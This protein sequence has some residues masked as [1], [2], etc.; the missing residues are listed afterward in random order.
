MEK[1]I[2]QRYSLL[3]PILP[4]VNGMMY[5]GKDL[6]LNRE[7]ILHLMENDDPAF[8]QAYIR[9]LRDVASFSDNRFLHILD[10][11]VDTQGVFAVL[12]IFGGQPLIQ[13]L[14]QHA[15]ST[16]EILG[17]LFALGKGMQDAMEAGIQGYSVLA[18]NLWVS[19]EGQLKVINYWE[20]GEPRARGAAGLCR[21]LAQLIS[22]SELMDGDGEA[23]ERVV[24]R[25]STDLPAAQQAVLL[26]LIREVRL[27]QG[28][29][30]SF[31]LGLQR[32]LDLPRSAPFDSF[33]AVRTTQAVPEIQ[34]DEEEY[35][36]EDEAAT[37]RV[38][39]VYTDEAKPKN[40]M[41][42]LGIILACLVVVMG[43]LVVWVN[44]KFVRKEVSPA[45][46]AAEKP[47]PTPTTPE[48]QAPAETDKNTK[49][50]VPADTGGDGPIEAPNLVGLTQEEAGKRAIDAGLKYQFFLERNANAQGTV[51]KQDPPA[52][53]QMEKGESVTF[54]V[55][56]GPD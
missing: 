35:E 15:W 29:L 51:F 13:M 6:S 32:L 10:M 27:E 24:R 28:T 50:S 37:R 14:R 18:D 42:R 25:F 38:H 33:E 36:E 12:K 47:A 7:V 23:V 22:R 11:G 41:L 19:G 34:E 3:Q 16:S 46:P 8:K 49:P 2:S 31:V 56:K 4:V 30:A 53:T 9:R 20:K 48:T 54:W 39:R 55:S 40:K 1:Q 17:L 52:K 26:D 21:L 5:L 45:P 44:G 43:G